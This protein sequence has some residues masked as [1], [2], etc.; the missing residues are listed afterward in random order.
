MA[1]T[2]DEQERQRAHAAAMA[3]LV[4]Q[5]AEAVGKLA[6]LD[7]KISQLSDTN[8]RERLGSRKVSE[9]TTKE[10]VEVVNKVRLGGFLELLGAR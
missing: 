9:M 10:K 8:F 6:R 2:I 7:E 1:M 5:R 4:R 3:E